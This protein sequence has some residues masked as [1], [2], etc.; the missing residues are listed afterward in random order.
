MWRKSLQ[1]GSM[2]APWIVEA[3]GQGDKE[4]FKGGK[5]VQKVAHLWGS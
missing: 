4:R 5:V 3:Q 2:S 1:K